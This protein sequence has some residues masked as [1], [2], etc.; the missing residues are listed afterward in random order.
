MNTGSMLAGTLS[1]LMHTVA[2]REY[3]MINNRHLCTAILYYI[4]SRNLQF[5]YTQ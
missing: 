2:H 3:I 5:T 1:T 4:R